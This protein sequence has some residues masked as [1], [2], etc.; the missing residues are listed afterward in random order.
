MSGG[1]SLGF[2]K[3]SGQSTSDQ[4]TFV[5]PQQSPFLQQLRSS[6]QA[7]AGNQA[8]PIQGLFGQAQGLQ[9]QGQQFLGGLQ[10]TQQQLGQP[11]A[12][13]FGQGQAGI[14]ALTGIAGGTDFASQQLQRQAAGQNP[15]LGA[16]IGQLGQDITRQF[17][18][19]LPGI[20]SQALGGGQLGGGRQGVAQGLLGQ[21]AIDAFQRGATD[22]R[23]QDIGRQ[24]QAAQALGG[25]QG[26]AAGQLAGLG[27]QQALGGAALGQ[28]GQ[29]ISGQLGLGGLSQLQGQFN[30]GLSPFQAQFGPL[31]SLAEILGPATVLSQGQA[32]STNKAF[33][34]SLAGGGGIGGSGFSG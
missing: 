28:Q 24:L 27:G 10:Q 3:S 1:G 34:L 30:L 19:L 32:Q 6:A 25:L 9:G 13:G 20:T 21:S 23:G 11:F 8:G 2:G 18:Q 17:G 12:G 29:G 7:L 15:Q 33:N 5:D 31:Q 4:R 26:G 14:D 16:Q 22:L